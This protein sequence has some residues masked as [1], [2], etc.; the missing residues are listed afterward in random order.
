[1]WLLV[2]AD[3]AA[4]NNQLEAVKE[5]LAHDKGMVDVLARNCFGKSALTEAFAV[6]NTDMVQVIDRP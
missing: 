3:W 2:C 4:Q 6:G 5:V 1:M